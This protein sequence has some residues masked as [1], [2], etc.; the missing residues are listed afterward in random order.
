MVTHSNDGVFAIRRGPWKWI[1]GVPVPQISP[2]ARKGHA[3]EF[4]PQ[5]Y[6]LSD[7]PKET[8]DLSEQHPEVAKELAALLQQERDAGHT[9][10]LPRTAAVPAKIPTQP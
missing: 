10:D 2:A 9:R 7:D 4:H 1:E 6:N 8:N 5:L 3:P